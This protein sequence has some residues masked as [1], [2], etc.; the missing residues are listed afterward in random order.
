MNQS[1]SLCKS[2]IVRGHNSFN[3][4]FKSSHKLSSGRIKLF[5]NETKHNFKSPQTKLKVGFVISAKRINSAVLR[6]RARRLIKEAYRNVKKN[7][8]IEIDAEV[9]IGLSD[10]GYELLKKNKDLEYRL[11]KID[12]SDAFSVLIFKLRNR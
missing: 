11:L 1:F 10:Y 2:E 8:P 4:I 7:Y 3:D 5:Y 9:L 12:I 6:N